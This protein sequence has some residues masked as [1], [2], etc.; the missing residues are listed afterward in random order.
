M[1]LRNS[2]VRTTLSMTR[3]SAT[4]A[5]MLRRAESSWLNGVLTLFGLRVGR[6]SRLTQIINWIFRVILITAHFAAIATLFVTLLHVPKTI[7][8]IAASASRI[9]SASGLY[10]YILCKRN[11]IAILIK[12][13]EATLM[14]R[15]S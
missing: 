11:T 4:V 1:N 14:T 15:D 6:S 7:V 3:R 10:L 12:N 5:V 13:I 2:R 9:I 8:V